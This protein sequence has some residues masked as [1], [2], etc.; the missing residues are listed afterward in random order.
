MATMKEKWPSEGKKAFQYRL[1]HTVM[2]YALKYIVIIKIQHFLN[3]KLSFILLDM[4]C[5]SV[6]ITCTVYMVLP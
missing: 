3:G 5:I 2:C 1:L 4:Q 6:K